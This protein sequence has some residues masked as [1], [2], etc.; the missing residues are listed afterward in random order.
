[1]HYAAMTGNT[2]PILHDWSNGILRSAGN[3]NFI[4]VAFEMNGTETQTGE[5]HMTAVN[6]Q[7]VS[8]HTAPGL[9]LGPFNVFFRQ[10]GVV[11][12]L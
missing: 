4:I 3:T 7:D 9:H 5:I 12:Y 2:S 10:F 6:I 8:L 11:H 1:M